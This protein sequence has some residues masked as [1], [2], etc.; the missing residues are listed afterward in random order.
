MLEQYPYTFSYAVEYQLIQTIIKY[1]C[2]YST[3][4]EPNNQ[5]KHTGM[6]CQDCEKNTQ[7]KL[8][9]K[10]GDKS[11]LTFPFSPQ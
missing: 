2:G 3:C 8:Q 1:L 10:R 9:S 6:I 4:I 11:H 5:W 7:F